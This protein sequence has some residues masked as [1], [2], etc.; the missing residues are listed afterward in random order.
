[1][2]RRDSH[3]A[4]DRGDG[5]AVLFLSVQQVAAARAVFFFLNILLNSKEFTDN[6]N[7]FRCTV[8]GIDSFLASLLNDSECYV[9]AHAPWGLTFNLAGRHV[10][11]GDLPGLK[12]AAGKP[13]LTNSIFMAL[14]F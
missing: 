6:Q 10:K 8:R 1:M 9:L 14:L 3:A 13:E 4:Y 2:C 11:P 5:G 7:C 12:C